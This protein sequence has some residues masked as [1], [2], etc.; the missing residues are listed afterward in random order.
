MRQLR[1][2]KKL[3]NLFFERKNSFHEIRFFT[4][5]KVVSN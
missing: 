3:K 1:I 4:V 5:S 2:Q